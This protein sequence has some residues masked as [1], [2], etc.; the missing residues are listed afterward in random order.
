MVDNFSELYHVD[1][2]HPQHKRMVDC[3]NDTMHLFEHGHTGLAVPGATVNPRFPVPQEP[4]DIQSAQLRS[5]DLEPA[6]FRDRVLD[7]RRAVQVDEV[8]LRDE[9]REDAAPPEPLV[10]G[11]LL[12]Q[13]LSRK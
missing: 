4:T 6:D 7:V 2:L 11:R 12:E 1:F 13:A 10:R 5:L 8:V 3:C 9:A